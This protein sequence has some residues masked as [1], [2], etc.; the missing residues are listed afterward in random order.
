ML[1][2]DVA[3]GFAGFDGSAVEPGRA[4][5][6]LAARLPLTMPLSR[7]LLLHLENLFLVRLLPGFR[8]PTLN[9][10]C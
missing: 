1:T 7:R 5:L 10:A 2:Y 6:M 8:A 3:S 9:P 4:Q